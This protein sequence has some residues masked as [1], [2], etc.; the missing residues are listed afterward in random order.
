VVICGSQDEHVKI[1]CEEWD[2]LCI[3]GKGDTDEIAFL[4]SYRLI[5]AAE[6]DRDHQ[7][8]EMGEHIKL[9]IHVTKH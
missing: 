3:E 2:M 9:R 6:N 4:V 7:L 8:Q 5:E 1:H